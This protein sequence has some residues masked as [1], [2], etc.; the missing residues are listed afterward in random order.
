[1]MNKR[2]LLLQDLLRYS[3]HDQEL[4]RYLGEHSNLPGPRGNLEL[5]FAFGDYIAGKYSSDGSACRQL[6]RQ[7]ISID[8]DAAPVN[9]PKEF[10][11]FCGIIAAGKIGGIDKSEFS[12]SLDTIRRM[13]VDDR[14]RIREAVAMALQELL[15]ANPEAVIQE[16]YEW[17]NRDNPLE[18][19]AI[20]AGLADPPLLKNAQLARQ[21]LEFH[22]IILNRIVLFSN[23]KTVNYK[24]LEKGLGYTLSVVIAAIP[25]E[26]FANLAELGRRSD[27]SI[28]KIIK[29]NMKKNRLKRLA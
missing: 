19:R 11:P 17:L 28:Q 16:F 25:D 29:E 6:C 9:S 13:A 21:A 1:M 5:A 18:M 3:P 23:R 12:L 20:V 15:G 22:K 24:I 14:W 26:V 4:P 8:S 10:L 2:E 7:L 27:L